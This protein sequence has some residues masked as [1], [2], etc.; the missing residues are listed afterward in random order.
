[1]SNPDGRIPMNLD[2]QRFGRLVVGIL[3]HKTYGQ[4]YWT[5]KCDCGNNHI[6][7]TTLLRN[8][9]VKSCGCLK[10]DNPLK[11]RH[12]HTRGRRETRVH[13]SWSGM[14]SRCYN[15]SH[16]RFTDWGGRG[17]TVCE[18]WHTFEN[19]LAD[20]GE[21]PKGKSIDRRDNNGNYEPGNCKWS[22]PLEQGSNKR[23]Y[24]KNHSK[25]CVICGSKFM[26]VMPRASLCSPECKK[27]Y[28]RLYSQERRKR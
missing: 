6:A 28:N 23:S 19:F 17:I 22:T 26:A 21:P 9:K 1:M 4:Y 20:M 25:T 15:S 14:M 11:V 5:C 24:G 8:G 27:E 16:K 2:G 18:R 7:R 10:K 3:H 13:K 12:G